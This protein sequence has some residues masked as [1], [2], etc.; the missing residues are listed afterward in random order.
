MTD[1]LNWPF[2]AVG[3]ALDAFAVALAGLLW[4]AISADVL[5]QLSDG[6]AAFWAQIGGLWTTVGGV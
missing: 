4:T 2:Q 5:M 1:L 6:L 3:G